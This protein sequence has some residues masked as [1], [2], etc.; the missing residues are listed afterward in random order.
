MKQVADAPFYI[1]EDFFS[2]LTELL[3]SLVLALGMLFVWFVYSKFPTA[4]HPR[5]SD[6]ASA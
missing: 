2:S 4:P 5:F 1:S 6:S 3:D